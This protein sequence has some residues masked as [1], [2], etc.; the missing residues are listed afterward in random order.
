MCSS[1]LLATLTLWVSSYGLRRHQ[2]SFLIR[3]EGTHFKVKRGQPSVGIIRLFD[4]LAHQT[5]LIKGTIRG[6]RKPRGVML[7]CS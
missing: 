7:N 4:Q 1:I 6:Q 5:P 2:E 3:R